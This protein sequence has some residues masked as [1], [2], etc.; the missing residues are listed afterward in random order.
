MSTPSK[1]MVF[2][3]GLTHAALMN[4]NV[5]LATP[6]VEVKNATVPTEERFC[7]IP[8]LDFMVLNVVAPMTLS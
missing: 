2:N 7:D 4:G 1:F 8:A 6:V 3:Q 5:I